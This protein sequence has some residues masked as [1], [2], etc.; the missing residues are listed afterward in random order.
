MR[1]TEVVTRSVTVAGTRNREAR[2]GSYSVALGGDGVVL[3]L[4]SML[5]VISQLGSRNWSL[6]M[7]LWKPL[8]VMRWT[9]MD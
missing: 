3:M 2:E 4:M 8:A 9:V 7:M 1:V 5:D 6:R